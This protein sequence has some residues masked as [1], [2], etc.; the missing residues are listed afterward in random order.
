METDKEIQSIIEAMIKDQKVRKVLELGAVELL[1]ISRK[2]GRKEMR[3]LEDKAV[4]IGAKVEIVSE[5]TEEG[6]QFS[7]LGGVGAVLRFAV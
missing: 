3:D 1:I 7:N 2:I 5:E 6:K 4:K